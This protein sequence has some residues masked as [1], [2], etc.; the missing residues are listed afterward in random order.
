LEAVFGQRAKSWKVPCQPHYRT[1]SH[2]NTANE[3]LFPI[4]VK[5]SLKQPMVIM[6]AKSDEFFEESMKDRLFLLQKWSFYRTT[7]SF[8]AE[9]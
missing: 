3:S 4:Q 8:H 1:Q 9:N 2:R 7:E 6:A 5:V